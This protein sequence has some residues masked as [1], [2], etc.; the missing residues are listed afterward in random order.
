[1]SFLELGEMQIHWEITNIDFAMFWEHMYVCDNLIYKM[2]D[3]FLIRMNDGWF[4]RDEKN[5][6]ILF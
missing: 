4:S 1:M 3:D 6:K 5:H 2:N